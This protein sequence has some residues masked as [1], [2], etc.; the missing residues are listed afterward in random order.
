VA[1]VEQAELAELLEQV[2]L[3]LQQIKEMLVEVVLAAA[4][5][6]VAVVAVALELLVAMAQAAFAAQV[7][8]V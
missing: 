6:Q 2:V 5:P 7:E 8:Q 1:A 4:L 3:H